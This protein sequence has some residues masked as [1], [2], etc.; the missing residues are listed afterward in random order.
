MGDRDWMFSDPI[1]GWGLPNNPRPPPKGKLLRVGG[2]FIAVALVLYTLNARFGPVPGLPKSSGGAARSAP[3]QSIGMMPEFNPGQ[4]EVRDP[5]G[6]RLVLA[7]TRVSESQ[8]NGLEVRSS[9]ATLV[10][11]NEGSAEVHVRKSACGDSEKLLYDVPAPETI[12]RTWVGP[13]AEVKR[14]ITVGEGSPGPPSNYRPDANAP[15]RSAD[16]TRI[17]WPAMPTWSATRDGPWYERCRSEETVAIATGEAPEVN[18]GTPF[19]GPDAGWLREDSVLAGRVELVGEAGSRTVEVR[20]ALSPLVADPGLLP[21]SPI[22]SVDIA[23]ADPEVG[24][25][26]ERRGET[27]WLAVNTSPYY[28]D[29]RREND[30]PDVQ[31]MLANQSLVGP[32]WIVIGRNGDIRERILPPDDDVMPDRNSVL[33]A[34]GTL[35]P[36]SSRRSLPNRQQNPT[37]GS[38]FEVGL[39]DV[40]SGVLV[41]SSELAGPPIVP[42]ARRV[43]P[44]SYRAVVTQA[45]T[46][47]VS[48]TPGQTPSSAAGTTVT[49][50]TGINRAEMRSEPAFLTV[51][52]DDADVARWERGVPEGF[53]PLVSAHGQY[54]GLVVQSE[55]S[56]ALRVVPHDNLA[57]GLARMARDLWRCDR[58]DSG[59]VSMR[60]DT[61][62][63]LRWVMTCGSGEGGASV[64]WGLDERGEPVQLLVDLG[65]LPR[66]YN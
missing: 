27:G 22:A 31:V 15:L 53:D 44:G 58:F 40:P 29:D 23:L 56:A 43:R 4:A 6:L 62:E 16:G 63:R 46:P 28:G 41:V 60:D 66:N 25:W 48:A 1:P 61:D 2:G 9:R 65:V 51:F 7:I 34:L 30:P 57:P 32:A 21:I 47:L 64:W 35:P 50:P 55:E 49:G 12:G 36:H 33:P 38:A 26:V 8:P 42:L 10:I 18:P 5:S 17:V 54:Y 19:M 20:L 59:A 24:G 45:D 39:I 14:R 13:S 37:V 3:L 11:R 52:L